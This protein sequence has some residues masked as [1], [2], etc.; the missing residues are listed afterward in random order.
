VA[1]IAVVAPSAVTTPVPKKQEFALG[2]ARSV[3]L[4]EPYEFLEQEETSEEFARRQE[5]LREPK[6]LPE[7]EVSAVEYSRIHPGLRADR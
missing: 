5:A 7:V 3:V 4:R 1:T 6:D 2:F